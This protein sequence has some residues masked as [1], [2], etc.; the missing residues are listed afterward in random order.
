MIGLQELQF[1]LNLQMLKDLGRRKKS[2]PKVRSNYVRKKITK[3]K[4]MIIYKRF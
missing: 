1:S 2:N 3:E 4:T